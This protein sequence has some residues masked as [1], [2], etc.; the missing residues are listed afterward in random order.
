MPG[1]EGKGREG[2]KRRLSWEKG[3]LVACLILF[4]LS[5]FFVL[6]FFLLL[7]N[8]VGAVFMG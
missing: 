8:T 7:M 1:R 2:R 4:S 6:G 3:I 5:F